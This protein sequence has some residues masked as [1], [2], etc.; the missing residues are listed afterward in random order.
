MMTDLPVKITDELLLLK[1]LS[2][3]IP[4]LSSYPILVEKMNNLQTVGDQTISE[5]P[6]IYLMIEQIL[7]DL[8]Q[9]EDSREKMRENVRVNFP[10]L[11]T[12]DDF[13][14]I[15]VSKE[16]QEMLLGKL[17]LINFLTE[18]K[19]IFG[20]V[21]DNTLHWVHNIPDKVSLPVPMGL[22]TDLPISH[23]EWVDTIRM[24]NL[25]VY[26]NILS[27]LG[28]IVSKNIID[29]VYK[30]ISSTYMGLETFPVIINMLPKM[31]LDREK[32]GLLAAY[33]VSK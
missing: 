29:K 30:V 2:E 33:R 23:R 5:L 7:V 14:L 24:I 8:L 13:A 19:P 18:T 4:S 20:R 9:L 1:Q 12:R 3:R 26:K 6:S 32:I 28:P 17:F 31:I 25:E 27:S 15:F 10:T 16:I 22:R 21:F 11:L